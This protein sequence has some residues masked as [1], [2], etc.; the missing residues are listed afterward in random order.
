M[1][2]S[3]LIIIGILALSACDNGANTNSTGENLVRPAKVAVARTQLGEQNK[4]FPGVTEATR[5]SILAFRVSG[6]VIELPVLSGQILKK[7]ELIA[8]LDDA[9]YR[10][11][12][13]DRQA[14]YQLTKTDLD[15]QKTLYAQKHVAKSKLDSA[16]SKFEAA[17]AA[18]QQ[19]KDDL[20][21][22]RL[23]APYDGMIARVD[24]DNFQNVQAKEPIVQFQGVEKIDIVFNVPESL[25]LHLNKDNTNDGLVV[26]RFD[27]LPERTFNAQ[28]REHEALPDTATRSFKV[29]VSMPYPKDLTVLPGM[30]ASVLVDISDVYKTDHNGVLI[31]LEAVFEKDNQT[32]VWRLDETN[33]AHQVIV[34]TVRIQGDDILV[35][36][37]LNVGDRVIAAG[38]THV[39]EGQKVRPLV[40][41]R[42]L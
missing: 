24:I 17:Q 37:G 33:A 22:T 41:E 16:Q 9:V 6:Q 39:Q 1:K 11:T 5:K 10:N 23:T 19:A 34:N 27:S 30:S 42:G 36:K 26:V 18:L 12:L 8:R 38:V 2:H 3:V 20:A 25:L 7:G 35:D 32:Q 15:R 40:K 13:A 31:P 29:T 4:I 28:Y 14:T 21:Y